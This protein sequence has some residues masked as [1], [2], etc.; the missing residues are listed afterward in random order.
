MIG[1]NRVTRQ[2]TIAWDEI[3][4]PLIISFDEYLKKANRLS[5][6]NSFPFPYSIL[7]IPKGVISCK[8]LLN[9]ESAIFSDSKLTKLSIRSLLLLLPCAAPVRLRGL[10]LDVLVERTH[11]HICN[12]CYIIHLRTGAIR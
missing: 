3:G 1:A 11:D 9:H 5:F 8:V 12:H 4:P 10:I 2:H 7:E 6:R